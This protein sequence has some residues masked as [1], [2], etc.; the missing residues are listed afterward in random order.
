[1]ESTNSLDTREHAVSLF[2]HDD[3]I[4]LLT[5][6]ASK[7]TSSLVDSESDIS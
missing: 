1:M 2:V 7:Q 5:T 4:L 6:R 3:L